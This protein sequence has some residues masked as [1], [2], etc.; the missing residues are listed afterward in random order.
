MR[1][2]RDDEGARCLA[3][4]CLGNACEALALLHCFGICLQD[5]WPGYGLVFEL[6]FGVVRERVVLQKYFRYRVNTVMINGS[7]CDVEQCGYP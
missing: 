1:N 2:S 6:R 4:L 3:I 5:K 7:R